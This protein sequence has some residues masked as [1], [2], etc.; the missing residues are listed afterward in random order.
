MRC[1]GLSGVTHQ[2]D[3]SVRQTGRVTASPPKTA[4]PEPGFQRYRAVVAY[5]GSEFHGF[6]TSPGVPTVG[7][8]LTDAISRIV[9]HGINLVC[10]GRTDRGVHGWGQ[11]VSFDTSA[12]VDCARL[13]R[14]LN[15]MCA[16]DIV[17]RELTLA[18]DGFDARFSALN[19]TYRYRILNRPTPDPFL[20]GGT[21]HIRHPLDL[22]AMNAAG[23]LLVG[24]HDFTS[25]CRKRLVFVDGEETEAT[26]VRTL[27]TLEW[28]R[29]EED[30]A[31]LWIT[32]TAF[33]HQM[34]RAITGT[35]VDVGAGKLRV[36]D[37]ARILAARDRNTAGVVAPPHGLTFWSVQY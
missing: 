20:Y 29:A 36:E 6:A 31:E 4:P 8:M 16:P 27:L 22:E 25:L 35:L 30:L 7:G 15:S 23:Q 28:R 19:R 9:G 21:W 17:V 11:V 3:E 5:N 12:G 34:V 37:V 24:V 1:V 2:T 10:A 33:C 32:A 26:L 18:D 14:S 13:Q